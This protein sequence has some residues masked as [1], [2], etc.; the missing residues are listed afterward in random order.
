MTKIERTLNQVQEN[1]EEI[2]TQGELNSENKIQIRIML[3][4]IV[5]TTLEIQGDKVRV[6]LQN[7]R[8][9]INL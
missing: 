3:E 9:I 6:A 7:A 4:A 1:I 8:E 5:R 2:I